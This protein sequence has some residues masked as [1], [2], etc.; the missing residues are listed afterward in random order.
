[1]QLFWVTYRKKIDA[2]T[3]WFWHLRPHNNNYETICPMLKISHYTDYTPC[4]SD[5][6]E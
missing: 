5:T 1:M 3:A 6:D 4:I 2:K